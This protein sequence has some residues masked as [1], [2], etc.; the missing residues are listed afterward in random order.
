MR[1]GRPI[2]M[3]ASPFGFLTTDLF[4]A[5]AKLA[6]LREP[7]VPPRRDGKEEQLSFYE[8]ELLRLLWERAGQPVTREELEAH[9]DAIVV[10]SGFGGALAAKVLVEAGWRVLML[11]RGRWVARGPGEPA[12]ISCCLMASSCCLTAPNCPNCLL[13]KSISPRIIGQ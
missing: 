4:T 7:F 13:T 6:V 12:T 3:P 10:G 2:A 8:V 9:F 1:Y 5:R 11:E